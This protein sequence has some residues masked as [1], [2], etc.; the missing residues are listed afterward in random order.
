MNEKNTM[1]TKTTTN[2]IEFTNIQ[3]YK[4]IQTNKQQYINRRNK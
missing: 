3:I 2:E 1:T 4:H